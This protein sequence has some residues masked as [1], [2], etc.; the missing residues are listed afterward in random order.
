MAGRKLSEEHKIKIGINSRKRVHHLTER[1]RDHN[2]HVFLNIS[3]EF[4]KGTREGFCRKYSIKAS[5][6]RALFL[7]DNPAKTAKCWG[8]VLEHEDL[9]S[10]LTRI[11]TI[12][13]RKGKFKP[14]ADE[15]RSDK[16]LYTF[17]SKFGEI[18]YCS[19]Y[20]FEVT[21]GFSPNP[22]FSSR[23]LHSIHKWGVCHKDETIEAATHRIKIGKNNRVR[24]KTVGDKVFTF[25]HISGEVFTG[26]RDQLILKYELGDKAYCLLS[27]LFSNKPAKSVLSWKL[28]KETDGRN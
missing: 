11:T 24:V 23:K 10:A 26:T 27:K 9:D 1:V 14:V 28:I 4:F 20:E 25:E 16:N 18:L 17:I 5:S 8:L 12:Q 22:L 7:T 6:I 19:R 3:G 13:V 15:M 2:T 21:N